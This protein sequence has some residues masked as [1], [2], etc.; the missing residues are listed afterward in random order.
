M[1]NSLN[2]DIEVGEIVIIDPHVVDDELSEDT[3]FKVLGGFGMNCFF[4]NSDMTGVLMATEE[5]YRF[6]GYEIEPYLTAQ[7][8]D[9]YGKFGE[10]DGRTPIL[11]K[12][13]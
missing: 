12:V 7:Y 8:Q 6:Q 5:N 10:L 3:R 13:E 4:T 2:R 9:I 1:C 11:P